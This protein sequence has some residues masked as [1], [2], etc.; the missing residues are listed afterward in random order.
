MSVKSLNILGVTG[1]IG[2]SVA[3]VVLSA[4]ERFDVSVVSAH[5]NVLKLA[6]MAIKLK[7]KTALI[8]DHDQEEAL[9]KALSG[10]GVKILA[11][12][13]ALEE[14]AGQKVDLTLVALVGMAGLRPTL[15]AIR[16][17]EMV[18]IAN[19]EPLVAAG[20]LVME[21]AHKH[22]TKILP[23]DSE[24][25]AIFQVFD[26]E[27]VKGIE[28]II[29]TASGGPFRMASK[30]EINAASVEQALAHP[31]WS[32]GRKISIDSA[33][34]MNKALE[35]IEAHYL[36][37]MPAEKIDVVI[38]PQSVVHSFVEYKDG[39]VLAQMGAS[40]MRTPIAHALAWPERMDTPGKRLD[41]KALSS[42]DFEEPDLERFPAIA[43][44]YRALKDGPAA[45]I[46]LNAANEVAVDSFLKHRIKFP[47]IIACVE[48]ALDNVENLK[49]STIEEIEKLDTTVRQFTMNYID[50]TRHLTKV[51]P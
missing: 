16:G 6:E 3:D 10:A 12:L 27:R 35:I 37:D 20:V 41:F 17:S 30:E 51:T 34:M 9:R 7:A 11:G 43:L 15:A 14:V 39:S 1:S 40:D 33:T 29:L 21:E 47:D 36:F 45:C 50:T 18:A 38:H 24:H 22:G 2:Q 26:F 8:V 28:R 13:A 19:K 4:P 49:L 25:N 46:A 31:N 48:N 23:V 42:L 44:A 5:K 32:M